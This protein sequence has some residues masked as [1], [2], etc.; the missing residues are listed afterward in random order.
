MRAGAVVPGTDRVR[1]AARG[2]RSGAGHHGGDA[3]ENSRGKLVPLLAARGIPHVVRYERGAGRGRRS[4]RR[5]VPWASSNRRSRLG[6]R[7]CCTAATCRF[8]AQCAPGVCQ[9]GATGM[10]VYEVAREFKVDA[11]KMLTILRGM[12]ARVTSEASQVDDATVAK[13]RARLERERRAGHTD[14]E[15][16]LEAVVE[17]AQ[18]AGRRRRRRKEAEPDIVEERP[19]PTEA[20]ERVAERTACR[21]DGR[22]RRGHCRR[23]RRGSR[24]ARRGRGRAHHRGRRSGPGRGRARR[25]PACSEAAE[26]EEP[27]PEPEAPNRRRCSPA[28]E[29]AA[30]A[31]AA[32]EEPAP[33][34][35]SRP[36]RQRRRSSR[37][38]PQRHA[39][40]RRSRSCAVPPRCWARRRRGSSR[41]R[42]PAPR[43]AAGPHPGRG[44]HARRPAR[45]RAAGPAAAGL[46]GQWPARRRRQ[47]GQEEEEAAAG[48]P[49]RGAGEHRPRHERAEDGWQEA[50][51][52]SRGGAQ[53]R[54]HGAGAPAPRRRGGDDRARERVPHGRRAGAG[55]RRAGHADRGQRVQEPGPDGDHQP[56][57]RLRPD[58]AAAG[59]VRLPCRSR[60]GVRRASCGGARRRTSRRTCAAAAHRHDH[61]PRRPRQ[62]VAAGLHPQDQRHR[63]RVRRHHAAHRRVPRGPAGRPP[64]SRSWTRRVTPRSR[65]CVRAAR[66]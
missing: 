28:A 33:A 62:D 57:A 45:C 8:G 1:E 23:G 9:G 66:S 4:R 18:P 11:E 22:R 36:R 10:R 55:H 43:R 14:L 3:S 59:G 48:G 51:P 31:P 37:V 32:R 2:G 58:R 7:Q 13:L 20:V 35:R 44:L 38:R 49:G 5:S 52:P 54:Q 24:R 41:R 25:G 53:P 19:P 65:P 15:E 42:R 30:E 63:R 27:A 64:P 21:R 12:G 26:P 17:D 40:E 39:T 29:A 6:C 47:E 50:S 16:S 60:G 61:G 46:R 34:A 56:A